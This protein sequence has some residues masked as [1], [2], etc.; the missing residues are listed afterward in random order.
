M[1]LIGAF[2]QLLLGL[3]FESLNLFGCYH[4]TVFCARTEEQMSRLPWKNEAFGRDNGY[5]FVFWVKSLLWGSMRPFRDST[6][7]DEIQAFRISS[8][9]ETIG[10]GGRKL[11]LLTEGGFLVCFF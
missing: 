1:A 6:A 11:P 2:P 10:V 7:Y 3:G 9:C 8:L 5:S 4:T